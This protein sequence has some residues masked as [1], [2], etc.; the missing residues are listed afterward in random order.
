MTRLLRAAKV[1]RGGRA[2][3]TGRWSPASDP[4]GSGGNGRR[5]KTGVAP[6]AFLPFAAQR[7][8]SASNNTAVASARISVRPACGR[9][10][11]NTLA[12]ATCALRRVRWAARLVSP[13]KAPRSRA[14][15]IVAY[16]GFSLHAF[17]TRGVP[18]RSGLQQMHDPD[19]VLQDADPRIARTKANRLLLKRDAHRLPPLKLAPAKIGIIV[20]TVEVWRDRHFVLGDRLRASSCRA[21]WHSHNALS[22]SVAIRPRPVRSV[23]W[24][25]RCHLPGLPSY[26]KPAPR[27]RSANGVSAWARRVL[28]RRARPGDG[29]LYACD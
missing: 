15:C 1:E 7:N 14:A 27:S 29:S 6:P 26:R 22:S 21:V 2:A 18:P 16:P 4:S 23:P 28:P 5:G 20:R 25:A 3:A 12:P 10:S 24:R 19:P 17:A 13:F 11:K 9:C 8:R